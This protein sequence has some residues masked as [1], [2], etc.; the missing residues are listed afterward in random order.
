MTPSAACLSLVLA[1]VQAPPASPLPEHPR[2]DFQRAEW[3]NLNGPWQFWF[4]QQDSG[5]REIVVPF[6]WGSPLSGVPDSG[7][8]GWYAREIPVPDAWRG[9]RVFLVFGA[10]DW[11]TTAW[12]DGQTLGEHQGGYTPFSFELKNP[13]LG[14]SQR[15]LVRV[16]ATP[17]PFKP[18]G[19]H[20]Y[21]K[22]RALWHTLHLAARAH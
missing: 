19:H 10:S 7:D 13:R 11:R 17:P 12:L 3:L 16:D 21:G 4:G 9:Q 5:K 15:L 1:L 22:A 18:P 8:I 2:P 6:S 20:G 14:V